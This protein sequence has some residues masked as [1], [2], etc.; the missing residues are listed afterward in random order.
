MVK[1]TE[2]PEQQREM[3]QA[4][5]YAREYVQ[6]A[7]GTANRL[8]PYHGYVDRLAAVVRELLDMER[9]A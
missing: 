1:Q 8:P 3:R 5:M 9:M 2:T 4:L 6:S 7:Y